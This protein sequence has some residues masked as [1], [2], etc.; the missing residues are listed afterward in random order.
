L[1]PPHYT[2]FIEGKPLA[3]PEAACFAEWTRTGAKAHVHGAQGQPEFRRF[4]RNLAMP[5]K[6]E[7]RHNRK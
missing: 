1:S 6:Q 2:G 5:S 7:R 4:L 3:F